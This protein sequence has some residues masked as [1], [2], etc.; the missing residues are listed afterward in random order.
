MPG[1]VGLGDGLEALM[2][3]SKGGGFGSLNHCGD[4]EEEESGLHE[5]ERPGGRRLVLAI[6]KNNGNIGVGFRE[7]G[8]FCRSIRATEWFIDS[9]IVIT[10][11]S[12]QFRAMFCFPPAMLIFAVLAGCCFLTVDASED[13]IGEQVNARIEGG[14]AVTE[15]VIRVRR[16][17]ENDM[18]FSKYNPFYWEGRR[19]W[20]RVEDYTPRGERK[21]VFSLHTEWPQ[22]Y[23]PTR[24]SDFSAIYKGDPLGDETGRSKFAINTRMEHVGGFTHFRHELGELSFH[25]ITEDLKVGRLLSFD[26][27]FFNSE[28]LPGWA[29]K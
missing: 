4:Q 25:Q 24:G 14:I 10:P 3:R 15:G 12:V 26:F 27:R 17:H 6:L 1:K 22:D 23:I 20:F 29:K 13:E 16:R 18:D 21:I 11:R 5:Y 2:I 8:Q 7:A 9:V 28:S 19:A